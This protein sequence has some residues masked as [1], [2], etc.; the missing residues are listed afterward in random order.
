MNREIKFRC[1]DPKEGC[2]LMYRADEFRINANGSIVWSSN[3][4]SES[5]LMQYTGLKDK[6]GREIYE[7]DIIKYEADDFKI[8]TDV[9]KWDSKKVGFEP[10]D[11]EGIVGCNSNINDSQCEVVGNIY[12]NPDLLKKNG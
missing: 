5:I 8:E 10:F 4:H 12:A 11:F 2:G 7:G 3:P 9:V 6:N 1:W